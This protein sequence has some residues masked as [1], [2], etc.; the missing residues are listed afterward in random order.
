MCAY[1]DFNMFDIFTSKTIGIDLGTA[2][3]LVYVPHKDIVLNEPSIVAM[4]SD[5][6][7]ILAVGNAALEMVGRTPESITAQRPLKEGVIADYRVTEAMLRYFIDKTSQRIN[8]QKTDVLIAVSAGITSTERR[9]VIQAT[10][11][12]GANSVFIVKKPILAAVGA[13]VPVNSSTGSMIIDIGGGTTEV[14]IISLGGIVVS[15]STRVGGDRMDTSIIAYIKS[16]YNV[17]IGERTAEKLK[18]QIGSAVPQREEE[19]MEVSGLDMMTGL[20]KNIKV[21]N[22]HITDAVAEEIK[23]IIQTVK[24]VMR[25][26]PPELI[27]DIMERGMLLCGGVSYLRHL[28]DLLSEAIGV[29][30]FVADEPMLCVAKGTGVAIEN[31]EMYKRSIMNK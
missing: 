1:K 10:K 21:K 31:I 22:N 9:A 19:N 26:T 18:V 7:S 17:A 13:G 15:E 12:A 23:E 29:P 6:N 24:K 20:P 16:H 5:D 2:N 25:D 14:A 11:R 4:S 3:S 28:D 8:F 30:A 27:A